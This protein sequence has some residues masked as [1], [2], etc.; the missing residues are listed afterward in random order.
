MDNSASELA[1]IIGNECLAGKVRRL[2]RVVTNVYDRALSPFGIKINQ[3]SILVC[4]S[5]MGDATP[6]D[7]GKKLQMEKSTVSRNVNR[8][9]NSGWVE[10]VAPGAGGAQIL[11]ITP[12]GQRLL[13]DSHA[14]WQRA[15]QTALELLGA[16]GAQAL[17][18]LGERIRPK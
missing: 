10:D 18:L 2:S 5:I 15:Q 8:M 17:H 9:R 11:R 14:Q 16:D 13:L 1:F 3:A 4:L 12:S 6:G 7:I